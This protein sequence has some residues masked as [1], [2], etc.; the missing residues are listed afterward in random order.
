VSSLLRVVALVMFVL[1]ALVAL[2][3]A[4]VAHEAVLI[5]GGLAFW[6]ASDLV[7]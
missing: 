7:T 1:A 2:T 5:P 6:V 3:D 4:T